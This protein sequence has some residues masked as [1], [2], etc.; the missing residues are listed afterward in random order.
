MSDKYQ[1]INNLTIARYELLLP[2]EGCQQK[3]QT[4]P[5]P[6]PYGKASLN[7]IQYWNRIKKVVVHSTSKTFLQS[8]GLFGVLSLVLNCLGGQ[9]PKIVKSKKSIAAFK[10]ME[11]VLI[12]GSS[13]LRNRRLRGFC[14][15]WSFLAASAS[16]ELIG[17]LRTSVGLTKVLLVE[18][19]PLDYASLEALSGLDLV[20]E[21]KKP[22]N[23]CNE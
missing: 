1:Q 10:L 23:F 19:D 9:A 6:S 17:P 21:F 15:K 4:I 16:L 14:Y 11:N 8:P 2:L 7:H 22:D 5:S 20:F 12:G 3:I 18:L 13:H